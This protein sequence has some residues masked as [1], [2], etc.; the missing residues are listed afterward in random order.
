MGLEERVSRME[1]ELVALRAMLGAFIAAHHDSARQTTA[2]ALE[3]AEAY[4]RSS[5][6]AGSDEDARRL[7]LLIDG[8]ASMVDE[9]RDIR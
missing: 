6:E 7:Q 5:L 2:A 3:L 1:S 9:G 4:R 8:M